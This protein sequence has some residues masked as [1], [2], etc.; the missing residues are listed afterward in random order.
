MANKSLFQ[1]SRG[2][3][4]PSATAINAEGAP[5]YVFEVVA[6]FAEGTLGADHWVGR[7]E[8]IEI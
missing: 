5:A 7:I 8:A 1:S 3:Q 4:L 2:A 6:R